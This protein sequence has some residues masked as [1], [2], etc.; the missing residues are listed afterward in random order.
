MSSNNRK[1]QETIFVYLS[2]LS[3]PSKIAKSNWIGNCCNRQQSDGAIWL[4]KN[5][6]KPILFFTLWKAWQWY[7]LNI[8]QRYHISK[9][10]RLHWTNRQREFGAHNTSEYLLPAKTKSF[11]NQYCWFGFEFPDSVQSNHDEQ[12]YH[13]SRPLVNL[14]LLVSDWL[15]FSFYFLHIFSEST[16]PIVCRG[17]ICS[18]F[19]KPS[20]K[21]EWAKANQ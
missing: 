4:A 18:R 17:V 3:F 10:R 19:E 9:V 8:V 20:R 1:N 11:Q 12:T 13:E 2:N 14:K 6:K 21:F 7:L 16:E 15:Q 5:R